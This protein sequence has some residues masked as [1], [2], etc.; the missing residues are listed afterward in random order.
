MHS[1]IK[2]FA[3]CL[4]YSRPRLG[5]CLSAGA[6]SGRGFPF[7]KICYQNQPRIQPAQHS[8]CAGSGVVA[9]APGSSHWYFQKYNTYGFHTI[10][11]YQQNVFTWSLGSLSMHKLPPPAPAAICNQWWFSGQL[12]EMKDSMLRVAAFYKELS[13]LSILLERKAAVA[14]LHNSRGHYRATWQMQDT[15]PAE[16][17]PATVWQILIKL[18]GQGTR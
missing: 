3:A 9:R 17:R 1:N 7:V 4:V 14:E 12:V 18:P 2:H 16:C 15:G 11:T 8:L 5:C 10:Q 6:R 13:F